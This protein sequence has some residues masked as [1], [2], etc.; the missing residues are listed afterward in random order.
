MPDYYAPNF[1][2]Q[3][4]VNFLP[5]FYRMELKLSLHLHI[6]HQNFN[7]SMLGKW[8]KTL[9]L[10]IFYLSLISHSNNGHLWNLPVPS[11][12]QPLVKVIDG[13]IKHDLKFR[14]P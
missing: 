14:L 4:A 7:S 3:K 10:K 1:N 9:S 13:Y 11:P 2:S 8:L 5:G 12:Q 6:D